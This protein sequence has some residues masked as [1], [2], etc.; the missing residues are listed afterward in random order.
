MLQALTM[1]NDKIL[2]DFKN[3]HHHHHLSE[4]NTPLQS[5]NNLQNDISLSPSQRQRSRSVGMSNSSRPI[6]EIHMTPLS[7]RTTTSSHILQQSA[8]N[9][10]LQPYP[11]DT[12]KTTLAS[13]TAPTQKGVVRANILFQILIFDRLSDTETKFQIINNVDVKGWLKSWNSI[14]Q[15]STPHKIFEDFVDVIE[16]HKKN[17][18]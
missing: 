3:E 1:E 16:E 6:S 14:T 10:T 11:N 15:K 9:L 18:K 8:P 12:L 7:A 5:N 13:S 4:T 17:T 2:N